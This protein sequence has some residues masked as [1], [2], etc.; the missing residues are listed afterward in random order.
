LLARYQT[1]FSDHF[2]HLLMT[3]TEGNA[4]FLAEI[5][6]NMEEKGQI[7]ETGRRPV[8]TGWQ[9]TTAIDHL[10]D[11][12]DKVEAVIRERVNRL[13][14]ALREILKYASVE[15]DEFISQVIAKVRYIAEDALLDDLNDKLLKIHQLIYEQGGKS[16]SNGSRIYEFVFRHNLIR[17]YVYANLPASK[18]ERIHAQIG[19]CL[20]RLYAPNPEEIATELAVHFFQG[21]VQD[22]AV[23][24]CLKAAQAANT[25]Y[26][27]AEAVRF[28]KMELA[29]LEERPTAQDYTEN[30]VRLLLALARAEEIG[31]DPQEEKD[32]IQ[33]GIVY[34]EDNLTL[35]ESVPEELRAE[36]YFQLGKLVVATL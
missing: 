4:L 19:E 31:G 35:L 29:A 22:K 7:V 27:A 8:S 34:L 32:H 30:K 11:L 24:Y 21:H 5:L 1:N 20:E 17:E 6:K 33:A 28:A 9:L 2:E 16:L 10:T 15:G 25:R 14:K 26:G 23:Y 13:E 12:P 36:I 3:R 18:R